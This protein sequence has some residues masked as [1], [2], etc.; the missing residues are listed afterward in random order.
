MYPKEG[1][2]VR[3]FDLVFV[4]CE[5]TGLEAKHE[6]V[7]IGFVKVKAGSYNV[8]AEKSIKIKPT[9]LADAN[10]E[11]LAISGYNEADWKDAVDLKTGLEDFLSY[12]DGAMLAGQNLAIDWFFLKKS[13]AECGLK[14]N[15]F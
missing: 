11:S 14:E 4:D 2:D 3:D 12:T 10:P 7:E 13:L 1:I 5:F 6:V 8:I 15:Y 9:R